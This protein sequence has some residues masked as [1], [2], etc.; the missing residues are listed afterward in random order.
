M[1]KKPDMIESVGRPSPDNRRGDSMTG[2]ISNDV[3][4]EILGA[5]AICDQCP[6]QAAIHNLAA[7]SGKTVQ[8]VKSDYARLYR[9][10]GGR[11]EPW[12]SEVPVR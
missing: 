1:G 3:L 11:G 9:L 12:T 4:E 10:A 6:S 5:Y 2:L 8:A 7:A